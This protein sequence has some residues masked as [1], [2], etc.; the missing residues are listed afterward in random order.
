M[1]AE[2]RMMTPTGPVFSVPPLAK[3]KRIS[4]VIN[5]SRQLLVQA[6]PNPKLDD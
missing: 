4:G 5:V 2:V 1:A 3:P 6:G